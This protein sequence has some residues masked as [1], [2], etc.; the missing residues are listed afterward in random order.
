MR[1]AFISYE[2][3]PDTADGGIATYIRQAAIMLSNRGHMVEVFAGSLSRQET[4]N[5]DGVIVHTL[6]GSRYDDFPGRAGAAFAARHRIVGFDVLEGPEYEAGAAGAVRLVPEMPLVIKLHTPWYLIEKMNSPVRSLMERARNPVR[7]AKDYAREVRSA[8]YP[9][10]YAPPTDKEK[11][12][13]ADADEVAAPSRSIGKIVTEAWHLDPV[14]VASVPY[15]YVAAPEMLAIPAETETNMVTFLGRL[16]QRKGVLNLAAAVPIVLKKHPEA[17]FQFVGKPLGSPDPS[18][19][20]RQY[21][22]NVLRPY[23]A[24]VDFLDSVP[25]TEI[26]SI[27]ARTDVCVY[28]SLWEN[29]PN[30]CLEAMSAARGVVGSSEGGMVDM[31]NGGEFGQVVSPESPSEIAAGISFFLSDAPR[32][33]ALGRAARQR[34]MTEYAPDRIGAI[35]EE[36]YIRAIKRRQQ[37][38]PRTF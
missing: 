5:D 23:S 33:Q 16:E 9:A 4:Y 24:S 11:V 29:F 36:S 15:P 2:Y 3:P 28:P 30:V 20:M 12:H 6:Q 27:L 32:R 22:Q 19:D 38:G 37:A 21:L 10:R 35:Q 8:L 1:V 18:Q 14:K 13:I 26:P 17:R 31:L 7:L 25:L 34:V